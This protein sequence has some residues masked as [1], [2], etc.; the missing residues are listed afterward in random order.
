MLSSSPLLPLLLFLPR[1]PPSAPSLLLKW[2]PHGALFPATKGFW[3]RAWEH[4]R[5]AS[6]FSVHANTPHFVHNMLELNSELKHLVKRGQLR[7][8]RHMFDKMSHRDEVSWTTIIAGYV[9]SSDPFE[10]LFMFLNLWVLPGLQKDQ[11]MISVALKACALGMNI[12]FGESLH[13]FSVKSSLVDSVFVSSS[14]VDMYM[15]VG[16]VEQGCRVFEEMETRNV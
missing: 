13:G 5:C 11:F 15:K 1:L 10:A 12:C 6:S 7:E 14:L 2:R 8:A 4:T 9:N 16:K 3:P